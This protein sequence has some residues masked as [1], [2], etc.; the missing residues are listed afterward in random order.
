[1]LAKEE[2]VGGK[3]GNCAWVCPLITSK[4]KNRNKDLISPKSKVVQG[5]LLLE[6]YQTLESE[7]QTL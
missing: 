5:L 1:M 3:L 7:I 4:G 2:T 6:L